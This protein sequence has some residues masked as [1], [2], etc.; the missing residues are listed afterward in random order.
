MKRD[1]WIFLFIFG[2]L[3][4]SWPFINI[5]H[6]VLAVYLFSAW[7]LFIGLIWLAS[8]FGKGTDKGGGA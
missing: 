2:I 3:L 4:F 1:V 6:D 8:F 7:I 5:F